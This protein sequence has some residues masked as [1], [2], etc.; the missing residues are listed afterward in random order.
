MHMVKCKVELGGDQRNTAALEGRRAPSWPEI[1][2]LQQIHGADH[3]IDIEFDHEEETPR[4]ADEKERLIFKYGTTVVELVYP[5]RN[6]N[7]EWTLP[8]H[9][10]K[11]PPKK[12]SKRYVP[13]DDDEE[14]GGLA[15]RYVEPLGDGKSPLED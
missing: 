1:A 4:A 13:V 8:G 6:P 9:G 7:M 10:K 12:G 2:V 11:G 15:N 5:G 14:D 3:V